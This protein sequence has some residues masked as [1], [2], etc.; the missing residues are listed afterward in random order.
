MIRRPPR[1]T[2]FP[3]TTLFRS[4]FEVLPPDALTP[5][6]RRYPWRNGDEAGAA[7]TL[8]LSNRDRPPATSAAKQR[9]P[10]ESTARKVPGK[11]RGRAAPPCEENGRGRERPAPPSV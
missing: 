9:A 1:S 5:Y 6:C 4:R 7:R 8:P 3:Y 10:G 2:L 11:S